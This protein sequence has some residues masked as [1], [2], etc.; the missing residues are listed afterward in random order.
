MAGLAEGRI[1]LD[2]PDLKR[3]DQIGQMARAVE[4]F[5]AN[6]E[7]VRRLTVEQEE[8][9]RR[10]AEE[11]R[12]LLEQLS[13]EFEATVRDALERALQKSTGVADHA[14][15]LAERVADADGQGQ[16][17]RTATGQTAGS[18][19]TVAAAAEE[20]AASISELSMRVSESARLSTEAAATSEASCTEISALDELAR[21]IG[22]IVQ[23][24]T[25]IAGQT[26]LLALN[27]TIEAARAGDAGRGFAVVASEVKQLAQQTEHAT[28]E[29]GE[30]VA[31]IQAATR[32]AVG[33][34][35]GIVGMAQRLS[36]TNAG[37][38]AAIEEQGAATQEIA[39][40]ITHAST[41]TG[42]VAEAIEGLGSSVEAAAHLAGGLE[43][44]GTDLTQD[45]RGLGE[46]VGLFLDKLR[47]A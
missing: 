35:Q 40:S 13:G 3:R 6:A 10:R 14:T 16:T 19:G 24:I 5:K 4:V 33:A 36:E 9:A 44:A 43:Q 22:D 25:G 46:R 26:N 38:A 11:R 12:S 30:K 41:G 45:M 37:I 29:I 1:D 31:A 47:A 8:S 21:R 15:R 28:K 2:I 32:R 34:V 20:L 42:I 7:A 27:A 39:R 18:V 23:L 17:V